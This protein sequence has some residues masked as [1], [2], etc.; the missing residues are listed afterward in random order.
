MISCRVVFG[1]SLRSFMNSA[2]M[3]VSFNNAGVSSEFTA[4]SCEMSVITRWKGYGRKRL[5]CDLNQCF[6]IYF[7]RKCKGKGKV[8]CL[9]HEGI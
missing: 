4:V 9:R 5:C 3:Y 2:T 7:E 1:V 8:V 6:D